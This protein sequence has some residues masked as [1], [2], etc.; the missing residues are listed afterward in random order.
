MKYRAHAIS[1]IL[2]VE[3]MKTRGTTVTCCV[4]RKS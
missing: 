2:K 3:S 1:A 4:P